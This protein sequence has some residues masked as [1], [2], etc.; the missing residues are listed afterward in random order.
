MGMG[1]A[2]KRVSFI[3]KLRNEKVAHCAAALTK[4][5]VLWS[6]RYAIASVSA[7]KARPARRNIDDAA[8]ESAERN[9]GMSITR[10]AGGSKVQQ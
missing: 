1:L 5:A 3:A 10:R 2:K 6:R 9:G 7:D 4:A 8:L